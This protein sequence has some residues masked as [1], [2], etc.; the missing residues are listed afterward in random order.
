MIRDLGPSQRTLAELI[1]AISERAWCSGWQAGME[2][3]LWAAMRSEAGGARPLSLGADERETPDAGERGLRRWIVFDNER[4]ETFV[5]FAEWT[6]RYSVW[7]AR[8]RSG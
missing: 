2:F 6:A 1:S 4:E 5:P 7:A 3:E 8:M